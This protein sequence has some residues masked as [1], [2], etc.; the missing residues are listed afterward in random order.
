MT[1]ETSGKRFKELLKPPSPMYDHS[2]NTGH[3]T[4]V[5][6]FNIVGREDQKLTRNIIE[7]ICIRVNNQS[8]NMNN[9]KY[10]IP[11]VWDEVMFNTP[12]LKLK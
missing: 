10:H 11:H 9:C 4:T 1:K 2:N 6:N 3:N 5:D 8:L 12:K 7:A